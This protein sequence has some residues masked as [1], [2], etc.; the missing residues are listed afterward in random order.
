MS[1][2]RMEVHLPKKE[3]TPVIVTIAN[4]QVHRDR[5]RITCS[6][7]IA[8]FGSRFLEIW[9]EV[10]TKSQTISN[11]IF[12]YYTTQKLSGWF[13]IFQWAICCIVLLSNCYN[14]IVERMPPEC[15]KLSCRTFLEGV[16]IEFPNVILILIGWLLCVM[17][18]T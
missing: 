8:S 16:G 5:K 3:T 4:I 6:D 9:W 2:T 14:F 12:L 17:L 7:I 10:Q 13:L 15:L 1:P 11:N 18:C